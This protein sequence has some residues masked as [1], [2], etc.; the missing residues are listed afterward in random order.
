MRGKSIRSGLRISSNSNLTANAIVRTYRQE[1]ERQTL[2]IKKAKLCEARLVFIVSA[3]KQLFEDE[4]FLNLLKA[5]SIDSL[6]K[7]V[8]D[9]IKSRSQNNNYEQASRAG[10]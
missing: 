2:L 1:V 8:A 9:Q 4:N 3:L 5:E 7:Y 6:P 10:V